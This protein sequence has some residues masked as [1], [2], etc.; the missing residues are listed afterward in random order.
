[1]VTATI[2][3]QTLEASITAAGASWIGYVN[4]D[5]ASYCATADDGWFFVSADLEQPDQAYN[6]TL[7]PQGTCPSRPIPFPIFKM[8]RKLPPPPSGQLPPS[9]G[10]PV[11]NTDIEP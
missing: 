8:K 3:P 6:V 10:I 7:E 5:P 1:M 9:P 4:F 11:L 2:H